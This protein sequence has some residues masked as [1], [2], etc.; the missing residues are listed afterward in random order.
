MRLEEFDYALPPELIAQRPA[1]P[2]DAAR[3]LVVD[4]ATGALAHRTFC[5]IGDYLRAGDVLV[6]N[7]TRVLPARLRGHR[8]TGGAVELLLLRPTADH[9]AWEA[10]V[11]P[12]RRLPPGSVVHVGGHPVVV[13]ERLPDGR[14][15]VRAAAGDD[16]AALMRRYGEPPLPPYIHQPLVSP[17]EYQTVYAR[18]DGAVAAPTAGLHFTPALLASLQAQGIAVVALTLHIGLGTF[19]RVAAA[20]VASHRMHP[21]YYTLSPAAASA[22]NGRRGRLVAVGTSTVRALETAVDTDGQVR[23]GEG[24]TELFIA[25]GHRFRAVEAL[26]TNFHLP[27]TTLLMLVCAFAGREVILRAYDEAI[28]AR[29]RFYS[30]GDAMLIV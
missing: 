6:V 19:Q 30:F 3:L 25:P 23:P 29:Y 22:I 7:D 15:L 13:G 12:G 14:R 8:P 11:R 26:V 10:L 18:A 27:R 2:R 17:E 16:L 9:A 28:R 1:V 4:R 24:W 5:E 20:D 21:E